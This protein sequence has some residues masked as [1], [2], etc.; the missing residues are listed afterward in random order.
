MH[1]NLLSKSNKTETNVSCKLHR[2]TRKNAEKVEHIPKCMAQL[3]N[4]QKFR[5]FALCSYQYVSIQSSVSRNSMG[6]KAATE[7]G[8]SLNFT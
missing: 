3:N 2:E 7:H 5:N 4:A 1:K 8:I 6:I